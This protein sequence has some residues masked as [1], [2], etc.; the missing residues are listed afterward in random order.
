MLRAQDV[1][2]KEDSPILTPEHPK[3]I[4]LA[5]RKMK[6]RGRRAFQAEMTLKYCNGKAR[7]AEEIF[8][9]GRKT[10][11]TGLGEKRT[12]IISLGSQAIYSGRK[13]WEEQH[14]EAAEALRQLAEAHAQQIQSY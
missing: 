6:G 13:R 4:R 12:G 3:D 5:A 7:Q 14:P 2:L 11:E 8:G 9:W 1:V 10:V